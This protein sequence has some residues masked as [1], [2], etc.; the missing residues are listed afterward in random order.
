[1]LEQRIEETGTGEGYHTRFG[2]ALAACYLLADR[3]RELG[4]DPVT[5]PP[6]IHPV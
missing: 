6:L 4:P 2:F 5:R 1:M 3:F